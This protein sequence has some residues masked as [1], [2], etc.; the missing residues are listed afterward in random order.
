[1]KLKASVK[2]LLERANVSVASDLPSVFKLFTS[3]LR[4]AQRLM[5]MELCEPKSKRLS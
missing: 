1:M 4:I 2:I 3:Y 5:I